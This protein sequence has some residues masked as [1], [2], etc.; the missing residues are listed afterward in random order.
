MALAVGAFVENI[1]LRLLT[2]T[3]T[4]TVRAAG[5]FDLFWG[6]SRL[7][8]TVRASAVRF[9]TMKPVLRGSTSRIIPFKSKRLR[10]R[11][12]E[13]LNFLVPRDR[14]PSWTETWR[15]SSMCHSARFRIH[16]E[17]DQGERPAV[18]RQGGRKKRG[19]LLKDH[20][21]WRRRRNDSRGRRIHI[22]YFPARIGQ[23][24][25]L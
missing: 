22:G 25:Y 17:V 4:V 11:W 18:F 7:F 16:V 1:N 6:R 9:L 3:Y 21:G 8:P 19:D 2:P 13:Y 20:Q 12:S 23:V 15:S 10:E 24:G 14:S 5:A